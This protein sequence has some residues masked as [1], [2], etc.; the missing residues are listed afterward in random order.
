MTA[1]REKH[2]PEVKGL[3]QKWG[4]MVAV[5]LL[6]LLAVLA[7]GGCAE[8]GTITAVEPTATAFPPPP[9]DIPPPPPGPTPVALDFPIAAVTQEANGSV[10]DQSCVGCHTD[11]E[12]LKALAEEEEVPEVEPEGEG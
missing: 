8:P 12:T 5:V 4:G 7:L 2:M 6:L 9:T 11:E 3:F 1:S 10:D